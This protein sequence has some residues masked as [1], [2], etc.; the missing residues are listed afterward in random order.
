MAYLGDIR[1]DNPEHEIGIIWGN[2]NA[3]S[4]RYKWNGALLDLNNIDPNDT[5]LYNYTYNYEDQKR[6]DNYISLGSLTSNNTVVLTAEKPVDSY[7]M[8]IVK[9]QY[10]NKYGNLDTNTITVEFEI[11][12]T[13]TETESLFDEG[14]DFK[15]VNV[16]FTPEKDNKYH[17]KVGETY[18]VDYSSLYY[19]VIRS[20]DINIISADLVTAS[21]YNFE[22]IQNMKPG[23]NPLVFGLSID[24]IEG[25]NE[26]EDDEIDA[27]KA[28]LSQ[29]FVVV[30]DTDFKNIVMTDALGME[31]N[32][33]EKLPS[34]FKIGENEY[35][36]F[37]HRD[38]GDQ[39]DLRDKSQSGENPTEDRVY[40]SYNAKLS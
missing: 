14:S 31:D 9:Y 10:T 30:Y 37:I 18:V 12:S 7:L 19:G 4:K 29:A 27:L 1:E 33:W 16:F 34:T 32:T 3:V 13:S 36:V 21:T 8:A 24:P 40:F 25:L 11:G 5:R 35:N 15:V 17:Y 6:E 23:L 22:I 20:A 26:M 2:I 39:V 28:E 38:R